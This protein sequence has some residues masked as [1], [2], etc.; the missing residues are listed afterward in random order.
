MITGIRVGNGF[1]VHAFSE[2]RELILGG[3]V[4]DYYRGLQGHSDADVLIHA[5]I[6]ALLGASNL[7]DIGLL[8]PDSDSQALGTFSY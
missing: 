7:G 3:V 4:I 8:F 5:I 2:G 1:D 6:D